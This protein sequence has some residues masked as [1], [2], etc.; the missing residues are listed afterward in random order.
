[1]IKFAILEPILENQVYHEGTPS[2]PPRKNFTFLQGGELTT[3][4]MQDY[5]K[6]INFNDAT[7]VN[8]LYEKIKDRT[9]I[10]DRQLVKFWCQRNGINYRQ[11]TALAFK[12]GCLDFLFTRLKPFD[13]GRKYRNTYLG[14]EDDLGVQE[15]IIKKIFA[16][17]GYTPSEI[18]YFWEGVITGTEKKSERINENSP[19]FSKRRFTKRISPTIRDPKKTLPR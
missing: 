14:K 19:P 3:E 13:Q 10:I 1:M 6:R 7:R 17:R 2:F 8:N 16:K 5:F 11:K 15:Q 4:L 9:Y 18:L 12:E